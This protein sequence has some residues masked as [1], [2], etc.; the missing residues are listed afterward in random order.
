MCGAS[1]LTP[2]REFFSPADPAQG[3]ALL[4]RFGVGRRGHESMH[5]TRLQDRCLFMARWS[6]LTMMTAV[7]GI[8][9]SLLTW[10]TRSGFNVRSAKCMEV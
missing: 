7:L 4:C 9:A 5:S 8:I 2:S 3:S 6:M 1:R 10:S